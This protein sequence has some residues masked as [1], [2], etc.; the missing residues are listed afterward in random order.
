[1]APERILGNHYHDVVSTGTIVLLVARHPTS[2]VSNASFISFLIGNLPAQIQHNNS[3]RK[4]NMKSSIKQGDDDNNKE[5][6]KSPFQNFIANNKSVL[7]LIQRLHFWN[8]F[9]AIFSGSYPRLCVCFCG[10]CYDQDTW[11]Q[12]K[13]KFLNVYGCVSSKRVVGLV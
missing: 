9:L 1:M 10:G 13:P 8:Y 12:P 3:P 11:H 5:S 2:T 7:T 6:L 4:K